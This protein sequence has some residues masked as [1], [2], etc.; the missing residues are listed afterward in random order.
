MLI[1]FKDKN[2]RYSSIG[3]NLIKQNMI[4]ENEKRYDYLVLGVSC[5]TD[6]DWGLLKNE[7]NDNIVN[8]NFDLSA[9]SLKRES[10]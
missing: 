10:L 6:K 5:F 1:I 7:Y 9:H 3:W 4:F 2:D 8:S